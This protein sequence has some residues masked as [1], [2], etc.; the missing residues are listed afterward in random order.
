MLLWIHV[1]E[2]K[3]KHNQIKHLKTKNITPP[4]KKKK[5][6]IPKQKLKA[7]ELKTIWDASFSHLKDIDGKLQMTKIALKTT[8]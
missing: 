3:P 5:E 1:S 2:K 7:R 8:K 6:N 4:P